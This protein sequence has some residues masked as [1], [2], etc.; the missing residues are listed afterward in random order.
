MAAKKLLQN[1]GVI[2]SSNSTSSTPKK[3]LKSKVSPSYRKGNSAKVKT[4]IVLSAPGQEEEKAGRPA[5]GQ[6]GKTLQ[7]AIEEM[8]SNDPESFPSNNLDDYSIVNAVE[9]VHY[10]AKTGRTEGTDSKILEQENLDRINSIL[11]DSKNVVALG[12]KAQL[13]VKNSSFSGNTFEAEH[14]SMQ[15][16]NKKYKS[17]G[18]T[19]SERHKDRVNQ[20]T[21]DIEK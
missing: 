5:A 15:A 10:K 1:R 2:P 18:S 12:E 20:W 16:L 4:T 3:K 9:D 8:H 19:P 11:Q 6:T 21:R 13:A 17:N 7:M 14:P